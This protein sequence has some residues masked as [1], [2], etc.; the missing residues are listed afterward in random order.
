MGVMEIGHAMVIISLETR[1]AHT[2]AINE[3][4][5][6]DVSVLNKKKEHLFEFVSN[7]NSY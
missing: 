2:S 4:S 1:R 6:I 5:Q 7:Y 3:T